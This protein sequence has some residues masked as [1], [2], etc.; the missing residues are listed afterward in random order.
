MRISKNILVVCLG[1]FVLLGCEKKD[2]TLPTTLVRVY[3]STIPLDS[4]AGIIYGTRF[5]F[6]QVI[7]SNANLN[8]SVYVPYS[9]GS[10]LELSDGF[11]DYAIDTANIP[12]ATYK[13]LSFTG[14]DNLFRILGTIGKTTFAFWSGDK[15]TLNFLDSLLTISKGEPVDLLVRIDFNKAFNPQLSGIDFS[16]AMDGNKDGT[17]SIEPSNSDGN[18]ALADSIFASIV[19]NCSI[20]RLN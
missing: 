10:Y 14:G 4:A 5:N 8:N 7:Y 11:D 13:S 19:K 18:A 2:L 17:I 6:T 12:C 9:Y 1:L 20:K 16:K 15:F 3:I